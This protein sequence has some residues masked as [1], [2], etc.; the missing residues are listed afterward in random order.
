VPHSLHLSLHHFPHPLSLWGV[1]KWPPT[2]A[3]GSF[4]SDAGDWLLHHIVSSKCPAWGHVAHKGC[5]QGPMP[6][7]SC[8]ILT[9]NEA[10]CGVAAQELPFFLR[11]RF[12]LSWHQRKSR[13][14]FISIN[15][16]QEWLGSGFKGDWVDI[17]GDRFCQLGRVEI[18]NKARMVDP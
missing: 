5:S 10:C 9:G 2:S 12:P 6:R 18:L 14:S 3:S 11:P 8:G 17:W 1:Y 15:W 7:V 16:N 4:L 13:S